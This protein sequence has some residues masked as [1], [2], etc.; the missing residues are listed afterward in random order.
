MRRSARIFAFLILAP[1]AATPE[2]KRAIT[3]TDLYAFHWIASP[4][5][6]PDG[7]TIVYTLVTVNAKHDGYETA[8]WIIPA[9]GGPARPLTYGPRDSS[10]C[11]SPNGKLLAFL[12]SPEPKDGKPQPPQVYLLSMAGGEARP[13]T[14]VPKG[15]ASPVWAPD[16]HSI[17]FSSTTLPKDFDKK[18][19]AEPESDVRVIV[20]AGYRANG[21]GYLDPERPSH[22]WTV[23]IPEAPAKP[24]KGKQ[25]TTGEFS[26]DE[27][28]WSRD[29]V[30]IY[31]TSNRVREPYYEPP[32]NEIYAV[33]AAGGSITKIASIDGTIA[34]FSLSPDGSHIAFAGSINHGE[35]SKERSYSQPDLFITAVSPGSVPRNLTAAYD[36]DIGG[37][38]G[39]DQAPPRASAPS[40]PYWGAGGAAI[41]VTSAAEGRANLERVN[42]ETGKVEAVTTGDQNLFA[43]S[44]TPDG[45]K[46][47]VLISTPTN[48]G[49]LFLLDSANGSLQQVT[50]VNDDLFSK[51]NMTA[52][53]TIWYKSFDGRRIQ[54]WV[55][56]P[57]DFQEGKKY[58]LI[59][60][61]HGGPHAAYGYTFD[62]EFQWMAA[63]DYVVLYPNPRGST[64][65]GQEF[66][67]V[68]QYHYPGDDFKDLMA[69]VDELIARGWVDPDKLGVTGGSGG[70]V[71]TNWTIGHTDRFKAAVSQRSIADWRD[72]WYTA[73]F[74]LFTPFWFRGA[75]WEQE[76]DFKERSPITYVEKIVTPLMLIEGEADL[77]TPP[78]AGGEQMFRALK[79]LKKPVVMVRFPGESHELSRSGKPAHR[80][81][82]LD[83]IVAWFDKY[84]DAREIHT[85]DVN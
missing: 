14:D 40:T 48:I 15:A 46:A 13:V 61:I 83:H 72:F 82:R 80:V 66:G 34:E 5:I 45:S 25:L 37:G 12:R 74:T 2:S 64:S 22:I 79:Y 10:P 57:P 36:F 85:Y 27:P 75:P 18:P 23:N 30:Q 33:S 49:D 70:G 38:I 1:L 11:W 54:A 3:E 29:G 7:A 21:E 52:P 28:A 4:R 84:L 55:Q 59:L 73:D 71:L 78:G 63:K 26:E 6:S 51:L 77:R 9:A 20:K 35:N 47:A 41:F 76:A 31:F 62:H 44:A 65:Y 58:P 53:E 19:D 42:A 56:R 32:H 17:A 67:N 68:I 43:Y 50:H 81:E 24:G 69:G 16:G 8:L 60:D 39:G